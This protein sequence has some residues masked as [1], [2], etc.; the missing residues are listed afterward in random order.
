MISSLQ[1]GSGMKV[2]NN[3]TPNEGDEGVSRQTLNDWQ[4]KDADLQKQDEAARTGKP[5]NQVGKQ[6]EG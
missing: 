1:Q 6:A 4:R 5:G 3:Q 2:S